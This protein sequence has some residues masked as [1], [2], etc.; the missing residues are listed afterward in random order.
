M[1]LLSSWQYLG[2]STRV[3]RL[4][5]KLSAIL[6]PKAK[7]ARALGVTRR[8]LNYWLS[9]QR[10]IPLNS[11]TELLRLSG[12]NDPM[13]WLHRAT[14]PLDLIELLAAV[15]YA[16]G[17][18]VDSLSKVISTISVSPAAFTPVAAISSTPDWWKEGQRTREALD[19][20]TDPSE[21]M[22]LI[23]PLDL[24]L[25]SAPE[26]TAELALYVATRV[27]PKL[28]VSN[29]TVFCAAAG[30]YASSRRL[31]GRPGDASAILRLALPVAEK[32]G[33]LQLLARLYRRAA[34][35][36]ADRP[37]YRASLGITVEATSLALRGGH[38]EVLPQILVDLGMFLSLASQF[39][40][41]VTVLQQ[42]LA[43]LPETDHMHLC[44]AYFSLGTA[45]RSLGDHEAAAC[46]FAKAAEHTAEA[47]TYNRACLL[48]QA[49]EASLATKDYDSAIDA[50][51]SAMALF[52]SV[53]PV[54]Q[55][56]VAVDLAGVLLSL[57]RL[58]EVRAIARKLIYLLQ[59]HAHQSMG[60]EV[61]TQHA[62][63]LLIGS[64]Q[65]LQEHFSRLR[66]QARILVK[67]HPFGR[68]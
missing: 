8:C 35:V 7:A 15:P 4:L 41:A 13:A 19:S 59:P 2:G 20:I 48:H 50:Y 39:Q 5:E 10:P 68:A 63:K 42:A 11:L 67:A 62:Q 3:K 9:G 64:D 28:P 30:V 51:N 22:S 61:M 66:A 38:F 44:G 16:D 54:T 65:Q 47:Q 60:A 43:S 21:A 55:A 12:V 40:P 6:P 45:Y 14:S 34:C 33:D 32:T 57:D 25:Q 52:A 26:E 24:L 37:D 46:A 49:A 36:L 17:E 18:T 23:E 56:Y 29:G 27:A 53:N 1:L 58:E 31:T